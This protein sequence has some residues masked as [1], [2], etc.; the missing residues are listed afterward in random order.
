[1]KESTERLPLEQKRRR[2][3]H[4]DGW[5]FSEEDVKVMCDSI[6]KDVIFLLGTENIKHEPLIC[7]RYNY[8]VQII[9]QRSGLYEK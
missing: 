9:K 8:I 7:A 5:G 4:S 1:M 6:I 2:L 3:K